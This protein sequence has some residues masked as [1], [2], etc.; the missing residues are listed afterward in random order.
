MFPPVYLVSTDD[1]DIV[2][3]RSSQAHFV[4]PQMSQMSQINSVRKLILFFHR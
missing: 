1:A 2:D 4:F 3:K